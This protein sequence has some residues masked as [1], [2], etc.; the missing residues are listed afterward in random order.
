MVKTTDNP[1]RVWQLPDDKKELLD[2]VS[3]IHHKDYFAGDFNREPLKVFMEMQSDLQTLSL[4][5]MVL[6][7]PGGVQ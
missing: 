3:R 7:H 4:A 2:L 5:V 6:L 1:N